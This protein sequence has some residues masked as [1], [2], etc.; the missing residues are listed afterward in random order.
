MVGEGD[1]DQLRFGQRSSLNGRNI[2]KII[3]FN[4]NRTTNLY[5]CYEKHGPFCFHECYNLIILNIDSK[6]FFGKDFILIFISRVKIIYLTEFLIIWID[7]WINQRMCL[8]NFKL[9]RASGLSYVM[10]V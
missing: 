3:I 7:N 5:G 1:A 6:H 10:T 4:I 9:Q 2:Y 8:V